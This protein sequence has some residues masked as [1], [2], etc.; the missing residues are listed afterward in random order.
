M[1][2]A[3]A[4][5][6]TLKEMEKALSLPPQKTLHPAMGELLRTL[7]AEATKKRPYELTTANT[8][9]GQTG[10]KFDRD[11]LTL[12]GRHYGA[13]MQQADFQKDTEN[14]RKAIN[15]WAQK[16]TRGRIKDLLAPRTIDAAT[17]L[18][19]VNAVYF[20]GAWE[21]QFQER[22]TKPA[23][24]HLA[25]GKTVKAPT[26]VQS[27]SFPFV[28]TDDADV[29]EMPYKGGEAS[30]V[31][32]LPKKKDGLPVLEKALTADKLATLLGKLGAPRKVMIHLPKFKFTQGT[33]LKEPLKE[34]GMKKAFA[35]GADFSGMDASGELFIGDVV[36][37]AF[38]DVNEKGTEAAAA[39]AVVMTFGGV[40]VPPPTFRADHPFLFLIRAKK[41][42]TILFLGRLS[43]PTKS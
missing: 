6:D 39:T 23:D 4:R 31:I 34:M 25:G 36:H 1:T 19:L 38:V 9:F 30:M 33:S 2:S 21:H 26:M 16:Q 20:K 27:E 22:W 32:I 10:H 42:G 24:F 8:L 37:K 7:S 15:A 12:L 11:F 14:A 35:R 17:R 5:G 41:S 29:L 28:Q 18:V 40:P 13:G 43:D 3:G